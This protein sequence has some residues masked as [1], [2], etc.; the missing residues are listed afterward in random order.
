MGNKICSHP[1]VI[2]TEDIALHFKS[3]NLTRDV[4]PIV[5]K[6]RKQGADLCLDQADFMRIFDVVSDVQKHFDVFDTN[7]DGKIDAHEVIMVYIL[8]S[9]GSEDLKIDTVFSVY[10]FARR[11]GG[12]LNFEEV[13]ILLHACVQGVRKVCD[14]EFGIADDEIYFHCLSLFDMHRKGRDGAID[15]KDF[16]AW[17][18]EDP[19]PHAFVSLLND[20]QGL[21]DI[22]AA[23]LERNMKQALVFQ[24]LACG[25]LHVSPDD[26]LG[27]SEFRASL[28]DAS[29]E[30]LEHVVEMMVAGQDSGRIYSDRFHEI[31]R[32]WNIFN[33]CDIDKSHTLDVKELEIVLWFHLRSRPTRGHLQKFMEYLKL[34]I[35]GEM[36][37]IQWVEACIVPK[38]S[39]DNPVQK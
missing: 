9:T 4:I 18:R 20:A 19:G 30:E 36:S 34:D 15:R 14:A 17:I 8:L 38:S 22:F 16:E 28:D 1:R 29:Q 32:P 13:M 23:E 24:M 39:S 10:D 11:K 6:W 26:L 5:D 7:R 21:P 37:R 31:L 12:T 27:S 33:E 3:S 25:K 35:D 2:L